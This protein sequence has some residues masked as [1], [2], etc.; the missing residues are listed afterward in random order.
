MNACCTEEPYK[1]ISAEPPVNIE[2]GFTT[3]GICQLTSSDTITKG[4]DYSKRSG[5]CGPSE[6]TVKTSIPKATCSVVKKTPCA[7]LSTI[8]GIDHE[9]QVPA[10]ESACSSQTGCCVK[11]TCTAA[12]IGDTTAGS[13]GHKEN[14]NS[15]SFADLD[16]PLTAQE[17]E[18]CL[19]RHAVPR[20]SLYQLLDMR[21]L[22]LRSLLRSP[23]VLLSSP[24]KHVGIS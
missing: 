1:S 12:P 23:V 21:S 8:T 20:S 4:D 7:A 11:T 2:K 22:Q 6:L 24:P 18:S 19:A 10:A 9:P 15:C 3:H 13:A 16:F 17:V 5:C 14:T